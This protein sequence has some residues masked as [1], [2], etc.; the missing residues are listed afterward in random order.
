MENDNIFAQ[1]KAAKKDFWITLN[2]SVINLSIPEKSLS[3]VPF[4]TRDF[5][6]ISICELIFE[7]TR[8]RSLT[9]VIFPVA[10]SG[11]LNQVT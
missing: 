7:L 1:L 6:L 10:I 5:R 4:A 9:C 3:N 11:S 8:G 2:S